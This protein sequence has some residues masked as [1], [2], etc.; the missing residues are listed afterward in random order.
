MSES[1]SHTV[2]PIPYESSTDCQWV[3]EFESS[4]WK[5]DKPSSFNVMCR[6]DNWIEK[7]KFEIFFKSQKVC[8]SIQKTF[9]ERE[10]CISE[11][12]FE[13]LTAVENLPLVNSSLGLRMIFIHDQ[14]SPPGWFYLVVWRHGV[15][16]IWLFAILTMVRL[17]ER[18]PPT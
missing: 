10:K 1:M 16:S 13:N 4:G 14:K 12:F 6:P 7:N 17:L 18:L 2:W 9:R 3:I 5:Y 8:F 15:S 11:Y